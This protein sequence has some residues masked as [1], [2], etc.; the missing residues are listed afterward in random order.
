MD[1][2]KQKKSVYND[3]IIKGIMERYGFKRNY[4]IKAIRGD[5][6]GKI[7]IQMQ[8]EYKEL[9]RETNLII[10]KKLDEL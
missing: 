6:V 3:T 1:K 10:N 4:V 7:P 5:R 8:E 2:T 9:L